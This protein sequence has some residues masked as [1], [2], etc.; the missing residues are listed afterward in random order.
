M[1]ALPTATV[2]PEIPLGDW[3][4]SVVDW[5]TDQLDWLFEGLNS[6][7]DGWVDLI[8]DPLLQV[9]IIA[10]IAVLALMALLV[11][12]VAFSIATVIGFLIIDGLDLFPQTIETVALVLVAAII[13]IVIA[14]PV[15]ILAARSQGFSNTIRPA[16]DLMQTLPAYVYLLPFLFLMGPGAAPAVLA[17][18]IFAMPPGVRLTELGI[19]Q[20]D[21]E[22]VEA[23][24]AFGATPREVLRGIQ[25]PLATPTIMAG[26]NQVI[27][28]SLSM[29]VIAA[30][31]GAEGLG[32][33]VLQA[34]S[35]LQIGPGT[36]AGI[37]VV[38]LAIY[39]DRLTD[40]LAKPELGTLPR[41]R[42]VAR[43]RAQ[44]GTTMAE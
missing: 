34:L 14:V 18:V 29:V 35:T 21:Q 31:V 33:D 37:A 6:F 43:A 38:I 28:L 7:I 8:A 32:K 3:A 26:I 5:M 19:R 11:R 23:G 16:L 24:Q 9:P 20:V 25:V 4:T 39:L 22:M 30:V 10:I 17:T 36:E 15:G 27:M 44:A 42:E 2:A 1:T 40:A 12:G 13:A 41:L